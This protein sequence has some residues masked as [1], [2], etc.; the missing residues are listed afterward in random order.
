M[1]THKKGHALM[2]RQFKVPDMS[3]CP[4][5]CAVFYCKH[6]IFIVATDQQY[7]PEGNNECQFALTFF[8]RILCYNSTS[9]VSLTIRFVFIVIPL[10]IYQ[11]IVTCTVNLHSIGMHFVTAGAPYDLKFNSSFL[12]MGSSFN[13]GI[14]YVCMNA[15]FASWIQR[16]TLLFVPN[17]PTTTLNDFSRNLPRHSSS[18][19]ALLTALFFPLLCTEHVS[20]FC[21]TDYPVT[22]FSSVT[23]GVMFG[24]LCPFQL[25]PVSAVNLTFLFIR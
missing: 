2:L 17:G 10:S 19:C 24:L 18:S 22:L 15:G 14:N 20:V 13:Q 12:F 23:S 6:W 3:A 7:P 11:F 5:T 4:V 1:E 8:L 21:G 25:F 9:A 16:T